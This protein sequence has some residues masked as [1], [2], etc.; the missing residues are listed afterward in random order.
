MASGLAA[1]VKNLK[2]SKFTNLAKYCK[3]KK[4]DLLLR[5]GVFPYDYFDGPER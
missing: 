1:L 3:G 2:R 4:F 5:K